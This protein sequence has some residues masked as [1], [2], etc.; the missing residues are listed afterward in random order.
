MDAPGTPSGV[1]FLN[2]VT[3]TRLGMVRA[4]HLLDDLERA[5]ARN[6][7]WSAEAYAR[8]LQER[9]DQCKADALAAV[10][11]L[12]SASNLLAALVADP[13]DPDHDLAEALDELAHPRDGIDQYQAE[14]R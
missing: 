6:D 12:E 11:D 14:D 5:S 3:R 7:Y 8:Q 1:T 13:S 2:P 10:T 9:L 4:L